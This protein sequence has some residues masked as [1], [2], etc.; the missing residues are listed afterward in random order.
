MDT[1]LYESYELNRFES[2]YVMPVKARS[3]L[4]KK[5]FELWEEDL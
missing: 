4:D 5:M 2:Y 1:N 3:L